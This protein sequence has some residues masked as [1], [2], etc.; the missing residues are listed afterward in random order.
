MGVHRIQFAMI[1]LQ[2]LPRIVGVRHVLGL[3]LTNG[4]V[5]RRSSSAGAFDGHR[6][7][8]RNSVE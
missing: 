8:A 3:R 6:Q 7:I 5:R 4:S 1:C 2:L